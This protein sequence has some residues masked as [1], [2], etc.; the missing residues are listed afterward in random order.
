[1]TWNNPPKE[2]WINVY[3]HNQIIYTSK[4]VAITCQNDD[5]LYRIHVVL[6]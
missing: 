3:K 1:M 6:K 5:I 2:C 4:I